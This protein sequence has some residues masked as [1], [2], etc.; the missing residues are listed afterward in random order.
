MHGC[1][2]VRH[3]SGSPCT[4]ADVFGTSTDRHPRLPTCSA[5]LRLAIHGCRRV[6]H[7]YGS[8]CRVADVFGTST[9]RHARLPMCS[10]R[11]LLAVHGCR[12]VRQLYGIAR[13]VD[14]QQSLPMR[15]AP[16]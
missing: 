4:V 5:R 15:S 7:V 1:L 3:V 10:G 11:L 6:R 12:R 16:T 9:T 13:H 2:R 14:V 8:P